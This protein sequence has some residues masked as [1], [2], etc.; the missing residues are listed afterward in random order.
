MKLYYKT[1]TIIVGDCLNHITELTNESIDIVVTS[2]PFNIGVNYN[3][4]DDRRP[5]EEYLQWLREVG[6]A[7]LHVLK[8]GGSLFLN[9]GATNVSPWV[10]FDVANVFRDLF[11][12]QNHIIWVKSISIGDDT[13]GHFKPINS[14]RFLNHN[15]EAIFHFSKTGTVPIDRLAIGVPFKDK[16]N[17]TRR[18]HAQDKRCAGDIWFVPYD[19]VTSRTQKFDH[20]AGFPIELVKRCLRLHGVTEQSIVLDP[21]MGTGTTLVAAAQLGCHGVGI[22]LDAAYATRALDRLR[23]SIDDFKF[24]EDSTANRYST[25]TDPQK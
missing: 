14:S 11:I 15:H 24:W 22:E 12:L 6:T 20:P 2:P 5:R 23:V 9:I 1:Q 21:F 13:V 16:E 10:S 7:I 3:S 4:Y 18:D 19:T 8:P 25:T 17:I